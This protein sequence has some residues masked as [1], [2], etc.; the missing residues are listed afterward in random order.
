MNSGDTSNEL[1]QADAAIQ[2]GRFDA[3]SRFLDRAA[4]SG[5]E[6][7]QIADLGR[8]LRYAMAQHE[9]GVRGSVRIGFWLAL[10][11]YIVLSM[12]QPDEWTIRVWLA[13]E[14]LVIPIVAGVLVG[15]RHSGQ[16][17]RGR[18][19]WDGARSGGIAMACYAAFNTL[20]LAGNLHKP[21]SDA[22]DEYFAALLTVVLYGAA[23]GLVAGLASAGASRGAPKEEHA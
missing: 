15:M 16:R 1:T 20:I 14:F 9:R 19:F 23:A 6:P 3:A 4:A 13:A 8:K 10:V 18:A 7:R 11:G 21:S 5:A 12:R 22:F 2:Q 17:S